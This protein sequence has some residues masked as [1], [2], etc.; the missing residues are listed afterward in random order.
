MAYIVEITSH[1][2]TEYIVIV[3]IIIKKNDDDDDEEEAQCRES[4]A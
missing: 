1:T 4:L 3:I 2:H